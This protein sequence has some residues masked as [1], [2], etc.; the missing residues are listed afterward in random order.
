M[1][2]LEYFLLE[3]IDRFIDTIVLLGNVGL[4]KKMHNVGV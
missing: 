1:N 3:F 2:V 4:H